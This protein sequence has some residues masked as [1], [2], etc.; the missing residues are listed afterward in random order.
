MA[1]TL[2]G[3]ISQTLVPKIGGGLVAAREI[4]VG[5]DAAKSLIREGKSAQI[6]NLMQTGKQYGMTTLEDELLKAYADGLITADDCIAKANRPDD[7]RRR[8]D[9]VQPKQQA[10]SLEGLGHRAPTAVGA[11]RGSSDGS[12]LEGSGLGGSGLGGGSGAPRARSGVTGVTGVTGG[13]Q[14][15]AFGEASGLKMRRPQRLI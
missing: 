8:I 15:S 14:Q 5:T 6:L 13:R 12:G 3:V 11:A 7:V 10:P 4:L 9:T 1:S 2:Q